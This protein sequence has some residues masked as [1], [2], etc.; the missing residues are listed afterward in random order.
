MKKL[1]EGIDFYIENGKYV[2]TEHYLLNRKSCCHSGCR[3]CPYG[4]IMELGKYI[5]KAQGA[6]YPVTVIAFL[7]KG[8]DGREYAKVEGSESAVPVDELQRVVKTSSKK[9]Q[10]KRLF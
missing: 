4:T 3:H 2:F 6:D 5:W 10:P 1:V 9:P 8:P 7:G